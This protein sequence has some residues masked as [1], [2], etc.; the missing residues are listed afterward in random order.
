VS[1]LRNWSNALK[2]QYSSSTAWHI[3][4][5]YSDRAVAAASLSL[6][7][8]LSTLAGMETVLAHYGWLDYVKK[9]CWLVSM[10]KTVNIKIA[11]QKKKIGF[12]N[13]FLG[14]V[15]VPT[16]VA[17]LKQCQLQIIKFVDE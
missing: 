14:G 8:L 7:I 2:Q 12:F 16:K 15:S 13:F 9:K 5:I 3:L 6:I 4:V 11:Y 17:E 10:R 1:N